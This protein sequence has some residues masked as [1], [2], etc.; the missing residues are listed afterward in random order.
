MPSLA[1]TKKF[2]K[3]LMNEVVDVTHEGVGRTGN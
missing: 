3:I 1:I 2:G